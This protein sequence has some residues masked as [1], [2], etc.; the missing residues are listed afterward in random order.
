MTKYGLRKIK[1]LT[2]GMKMPYAMNSEKY[3]ILQRTAEDCPVKRKLEKSI[4]IKLN[5]HQTKFKI[6]RYIIVF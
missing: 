3:K 2:L 1:T 6:S 4:E 5:W